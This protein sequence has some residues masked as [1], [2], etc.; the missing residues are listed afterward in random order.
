MRSKWS[1]PGRFR[2]H[3]SAWEQEKLH[4][5]RQAARDFISDEESEVIFHFKNGTIVIQYRI[6]VLQICFV[7]FSAVI[8][9]LVI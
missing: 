2:A 6:W 7:F 5:K 9:H 1:G 3:T 4:V 8:G